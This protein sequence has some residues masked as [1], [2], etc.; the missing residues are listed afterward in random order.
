MAYAWCEKC[1]KERHYRALKGSKLS[2]VYCGGCGGVL[3][4]GKILP[5]SNPNCAEERLKREQSF[6]RRANM[7]IPTSL[8]PYQQDTPKIKVYLG[9]IPLCVICKCVENNPT[10]P[11]KQK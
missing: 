6:C 5:C 4:G 11:L 8:L 10:N 7:A 2:G 3:T 1:K 9:Q